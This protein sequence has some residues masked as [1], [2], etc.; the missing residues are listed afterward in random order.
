M[1]NIPRHGLGRSH[2]RQLR[3]SKYHARVD[4]AGFHGDDVD[5]A[6]VKPVAQALK[7]SGQSALGGPIEVIALAAAVP[8]NRRESA[9]KSLAL[10]LKMVGQDIEG[11]RAIR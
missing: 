3:P 8:G 10:L 1:V 6:V 11:K 7:I 9:D 2:Q 4:E 5:A